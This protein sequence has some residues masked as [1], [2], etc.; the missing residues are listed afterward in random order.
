MKRLVFLFLTVSVWL[1]PAVVA[2]TS[3]VQSNKLICLIPGAL[4]FTQSSFANLGFLSQAVGSEVSNLPLASPASG[5]IYKTDP[6]LNL[7]VP[8]DETLGP[9][10]TQ[11]PET[12]GRHKLYFAATYQFFRFEDIDGITLKKIPIFI[13]VPGQGFEPTNNRLDLTVHQTTAYLTFGLTSRV[14]L[15]VALPVLDINEQLITSGVEYNRASTVIVPVSSRSVSG[16]ATGLG[17]VVLA[18]KGTLWKPAHGGLAFGT[19]VR[20]PT[21]DA[22]NFLGAGTI[23]VKPFLSWSLGGRIAPHANISYEMNGESVLATN[24][25]GEKGHLPNR[26]FYSGGADVRATNWMTIDIDALS[27]RVFNSQRVSM[28]SVT[29][30]TQNMSY[31]SIAVTSE[32]YNRT[33]GSVGAKFKPFRNLILTGNLL[34]KLDQGGLRARTVPLGAVSYTF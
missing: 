33:D 22:K 2:Q 7:P 23:G 17:D 10:L 9:I 15:S 19:E 20:L 24:A 3:C 8:S 18:A 30:A 5:I 1:S 21:G 14:D 31:P 27:Q 25:A 13:N 12:I 32:S 34:I 16:S 28:T 11:R 29:Q 6:K 26:L 4:N